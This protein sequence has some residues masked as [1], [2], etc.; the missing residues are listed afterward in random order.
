MFLS[1]GTLKNLSVLFHF[2]MKGTSTT[3]FY[4]CKTIR[5]HSGTFQKAAPDIPKTFPFLLLIIFH[6]GQTEREVLAI[7][8]HR[9]FYLFYT[10]DFK[11]IANLFVFIGIEFILKV[12]RS[13]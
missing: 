5:N 6:F 4:A 8:R 11:S 1:V 3:D 10:C 7:I 2:K 9:F 12:Y 13:P